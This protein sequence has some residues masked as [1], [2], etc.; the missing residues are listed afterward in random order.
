M[1][2]KANL[3]RK[4]PSFIKKA[5][6]KVILVIA[7]TLALAV[8]F[9][10]Y[11]N[12][13]HVK[14]P[15]LK[16]L[17]GRTSLSLN[18]EKVEFSPLYPNILKLTN[19][20]FNKS[21]IGEIYV[22][23]D[24]PSLLTS[25]TLELKEFYARSADI[26]KEDLKKLSEEK[27]SF[28]NISIHKL[29]LVDTPL[30][31]E[32]LNAEHA[33]FSAKEVNLDAQGK[34]GF[35]QGTIKF[36]EGNLDGNNVRKFKASVKFEPEKIIVDDLSMQLFSGTI[37]CDAT[38]DRESKAINFTR[39]HL[40]NNIFLNIRDYAKKYRMF[41]QEASASNCVISLPK[42]DLLLGQISGQIYDLFIG[43]SNVSFDF[44]GTAGEISKP[45]ARLSADNSDVVISMKTDEAQLKLSGNI[46][47]G[48]YE[49]DATISGLNEIQQDLSVEK[50]LLHGAK[51]EP[52]AQL[53]EYLKDELFCMNTHIARAKIDKTEFVSHIDALPLSVKEVKLE[54]SNLKFERES[55][56]IEA[57]NG[58]VL[59]SFDQAF[60]LDL[61]LRRLESILSID[62]NNVTFS[63]PELTLQKSK[64]SLSASFDRDFNRFSGI[65]SAK[66][67]DL[68][69]LNSSLFPYLF[70]GKVSLTG[71]ISTKDDEKTVADDTQNLIENAVLSEQKTDKSP[72]AD[73]KQSF[74][75]RLEGR[76]SLNSD[77]ILVS[78]LGLDLV[79]G[80]TRQDYALNLEEFMNAIR[81]GD[82]VLYKLKATGDI[83][84]GGINTT[85]SGDLTSSH[86][87]LNSYYDLN[88]SSLQ[89]KATLVSLPKDSISYIRASGPVSELKFYITALTRGEEI[90]P[91]INVEVIGKNHES[92]DA[93]NETAVS[94]SDI[95]PS[96]ESD[97]NG[98][99]K[100]F[101]DKHQSETDSK[102]SESQSK[103]NKVAP[104]SFVIYE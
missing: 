99:V 80:G 28:E 35:K 9:I 103:D 94:D 5:A 6:K 55:K 17:E 31:F 102:E 93:A 41:A 66:D 60:Y 89:S 13:Q 23:Y 76:I 79:N 40:I 45:K 22:E 90:R 72:V 52:D 82:L 87:T 47:S 16:F 84:N 81:G 51:I 75:D 42:Y 77:G 12:G 95:S 100:L 85:L 4:E 73:N 59:F 97:S 30:Y 88:S 92:D 27:F 54:G 64:L 33:N 69:E 43:N 2:L 14:A 46:F 68:G 62:G 44:E 37:V 32:I 7:C 38:I 53:F 65:I 20:K 29:D 96:E 91:G 34:L 39:L 19:L 50:F 74:A 49:L 10:L 11:F 58:K 18:C 98:S 101:V 36:E 25:N 70:N 15:L 63:V 67:F 86:I 21:K 48:E 83:E 56:S 71:Q 61:Y 8:A 26:A 57:Q 3:K 1:A 104:D 78:S 24:L